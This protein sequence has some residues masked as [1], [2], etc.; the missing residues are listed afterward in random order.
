[1]P[2]IVDGRDLAERLSVRY[3]QVM[4]WSRD[5]EIPSI[6]CGR[7][8]LFNLDLV[9]DAMRERSRESREVATCA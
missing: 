3:E 1:M 9:L 2:I 4:E 8:V 7:R 5:G 6:R